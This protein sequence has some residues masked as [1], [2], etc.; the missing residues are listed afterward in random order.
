MPLI[1]P[2]K[3]LVTA[4][5][6]FRQVQDSLR[7]TLGVLTASTLTNGAILT[8][9]TLAVGNN[10]ISHGLGRNYQSYFLGRQ[11]SV[12]AASTITENT[13]TNINRA[14]FLILNSTAACAIDLLV[15]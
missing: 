14:V 5:P 13:S 2:F 11:R 10:Q 12:L 15:V 7:E 8:N 6:A 4:D 3:H 9:V 1:R